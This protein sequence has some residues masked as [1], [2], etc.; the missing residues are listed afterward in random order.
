[1]GIALAQSVQDRAIA[2]DMS[3]GGSK[4]VVKW[5]L[6]VKGGTR[7]AYVVNWPATAVKDLKV[8][9]PV[10]VAQFYRAFESTFGQFEALRADVRLK[11]ENTV[12]FMNE[13]LAN[14]VVA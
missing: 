13:L 6:P 1:M 11:Y 3:S 7:E 8:T 14:H 5:D 12:L 2:L 10:S 9:P 4:V